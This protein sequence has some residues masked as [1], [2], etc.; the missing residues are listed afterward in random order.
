MEK[1]E[2]AEKIARILPHADAVTMQ[3]IYRILVRRVNLAAVFG[4]EK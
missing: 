1:S 4:G 3:I 2:I